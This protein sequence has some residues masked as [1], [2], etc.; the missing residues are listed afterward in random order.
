MRRKLVLRIIRQVDE[1]E[2]DPARGW[3]IQPFCRHCHVDECGSVRRNSDSSAVR[4]TLGA[5][6][7]AVGCQTLL[8]EGPPTRRSFLCNHLPDITEIDMFVVVTATFQILYTLIVLSLDP[9]RVV[10]LKLSS[11]WRKEEGRSKGEQL[12]KSA[13]A[14]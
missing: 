14:N 7:R 4:V 9:R 12:A 2:S 1:G 3:P 8:Q 13:V 6:V 5:L 10:H 11:L